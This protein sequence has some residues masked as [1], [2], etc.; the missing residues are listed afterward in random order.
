MTNRIKTIIDNVSESVKA[1]PELISFLTLRKAVGWLGVLL[2]FS[3]ILGS[4]WFGQCQGVQPSISHYYFTNMREIF[5]GVLCAVGL[6]L[7][8]Y[9]GYSRLDNVSANMAGLFSF[10]VALFPTDMIPGHPC[11]QPNLSFIDIGFHSTIH[12]ACASLFFLTLAF[13]SIVLFTKSTHETKDQTPQKRNRNVIYKVCGYAMIFSIV[14]IGLYLF[15]MNGD[16]E[17]QLVFW[18]ET[19]ALLSFG[20]SWLTK[21]E[22]LLK[23]K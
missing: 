2:P 8:S 9:R 23:D 20:L 4:V 11:Q 19:L 21:G 12:F 18:F 16:S 15:A 7:F 22:A 14:L 6:F 13:M 10:G 3:L 5:V 1:D 17:N